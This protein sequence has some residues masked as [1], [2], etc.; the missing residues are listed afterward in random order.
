MFHGCLLE[1]SNGLQLTIQCLVV[2]HYN[3]GTIVV[4][5]GHT[6]KNLDVVL[7]EVHM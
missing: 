4:W 7:S 6:I 2:G 5:K 1:F 3:P